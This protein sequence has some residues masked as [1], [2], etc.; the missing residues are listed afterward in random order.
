MNEITTLNDLVDARAAATPERILLVDDKGRRLTCRAYRDESL[1]VARVLSELGIGEGTL[2]SWI[3]PTGIDALVVAAALSRLATVQNPII[4]IY[5][6]R[7]I[8][9]IVDEA[10]VDV[11]VVV[12]EWRGFNYLGL[13]E[14]LSVTRHGL[15]VLRMEDALRGDPARWAGFERRS[16]DA[17]GPAQWVFYT[18]GSTGHPK[19][20]RHTDAALLAAA[21]GMVDHLAISEHDRSGLAFPSPTSGGRST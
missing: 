1:R 10:S 13:A 15:G 4:P 21:R 7:E 16:H 9:H 14:G 2:V 8:G 6:E 3:L 11:L 17:L 19:G 20:V 5:R 12:P 18:S